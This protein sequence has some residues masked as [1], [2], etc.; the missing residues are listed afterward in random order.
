VK[1]SSQAEQ[2]AEFARLLDLRGTSGTPD[3]SQERSDSELTREDSF[4]TRRVDHPE[5][6]AVF[7]E[8]Y[9]RLGAALHQA[10]IQQGIRSVM[11][12]S[13]VEAEGKTLSATNL[14]LTLS[15]SFKKR[16][17]L[18][19]GDLR[20][21][22]IHS[23]LALQNA[24]GLSDL[25]KRPGG[26]SPERA[27]STT[28]SVI[29]GGHHDPDPVALLTSDA[30]RQFFEDMRERFDWVVVDTPPVMLFPDAGLFAGR[31]DTCLMVVSAATTASPIAAKAVAAIGATRI[32]G[33]VLNRAAPTDVAGGYG[34]GRYGYVG[35]DRRDRHLGWLRPSRR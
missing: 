30:A 34:Y 2:T 28:L 3:L 7:V 15:R 25:L 10:Q 31:V 12:A 8:Q 1:S 26:R 6:D 19:D 9:R 13:A 14:A 23:L 20:K 17:L 27:L 33:V 5:S 18:V 29:T 35:S 24:S 4:D 16:V 21:P 22:G 32:L 11:V